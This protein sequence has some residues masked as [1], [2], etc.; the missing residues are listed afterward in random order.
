MK[1]AQTDSPAVTQLFK[2]K[3]GAYPETLEGVEYREK[4]FDYIA[5]KYCI[6]TH[7]LRHLVM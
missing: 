7:V 6:K 3:Y 4:V 1:T 2:D 5:W